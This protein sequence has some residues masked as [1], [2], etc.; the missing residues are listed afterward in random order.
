M[1]IDHARLA[2]AVREAL[3]TPSV[4]IPT[5]GLRDTPDSSSPA[6]RWRCSPGSTNSGDYL[7][8][9]FDIEHEELV[10]VKDIECP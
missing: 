6:Q 8:T 5:E 2:A 9:T 3:F 1:A 7:G 10:L 4:R